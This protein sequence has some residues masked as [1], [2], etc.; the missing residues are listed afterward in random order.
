MRLLIISF[1]SIINKLSQKSM[2]TKNKKA[3]ELLQRLFSK[4]TRS[5]SVVIPLGFEPRTPTLKV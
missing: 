5:H 3:S 2:L 1:K 4:S